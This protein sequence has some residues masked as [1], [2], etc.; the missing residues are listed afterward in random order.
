MDDV[1]EKIRNLET[2]VKNLSNNLSSSCLQEL[3][4]EIKIAESL[5]NLFNNQEFRDRIEKIKNDIQSKTS[6]SVYTASDR[7]LRIN[8]VNQGAEKILLMNQFVNECVF[9]QENSLDLIEIESENALN[10]S[11]EAYNQLLSQKQYLE[12]KHR[13]IRNIF[14]LI[15]IFIS[16][17]IIRIIT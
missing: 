2:K 4:S 15:V 14:I 16:L 10:S 7:N 12:R 3:L 9:Q 8:N 6:T 17:V 1:E 11:N 5:T 13:F